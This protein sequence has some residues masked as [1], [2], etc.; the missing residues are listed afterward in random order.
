VYELLQLDGSTVTCYVVVGPRNKNKRT[1][2]IEGSNFIIPLDDN[3]ERKVIDVPAHILGQALPLH[4]FNLTGGYDVNHIPTGKL[5]SYLAIDIDGTAMML[6]SLNPTYVGKSNETII[7]CDARVSVPND[8]RYGWAD[9]VYLT[10]GGKVTQIVSI[11]TG[12]RMRVKGTTLFIPEKSRLFPVHGGDLVYCNCTADDP[13]SVNRQ[14]K[15]I[16]ATTD[17]LVDAVSRREKLLSIKI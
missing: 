1:G 11:P 12:G 10:S 16:L 7:S 9:G 6:N 4:Q 2:K 14:R 17:E 15:L 3:M 8:N 13:E 5:N